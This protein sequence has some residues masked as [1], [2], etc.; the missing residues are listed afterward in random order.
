MS[1]ARAPNAAWMNGKVVPFAEARVPIE[2][3]GLQFGESLY[4]V[5]AVTAGEVRDLDAHVARMRHCAEEIGLGA[6]VPADEEWQRL[7][8]ALRERD[9]LDEGLLYAQ[10]TG[11][12]ARR[13]HLPAGEP[14]PSFWA[15]LREYRFP[16]AEDVERG[17]SAITLP[18]PR[19]SRCDLKTPMLLPAVMA[20]REAQ[21]RGA[22]EASFF[23][24]EED[25]REGGSSTAL[26][27]EGRTLVSPRQTQ[28]L[29]P[30]TTGP[31]IQRLAEQAGLEVRSEPVALDRLL[32]AA[33]V[34]V[35]STTFLL[36]P[37]VKVDDATIGQGR[38]GP[39]ALDLA[40]RLRTHLAL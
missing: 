30:G 17:L 4:E 40:A 7:I 3:R 28:H 1:S 15:Y 38:P 18:D 2:D 14:T 35:A 34:M 13:S 32:A 22:A 26:L 16:R 23:G 33:E 10:L 21:A 29:L 24:P 31:V 9:P 39:V 11:G 19:W 27:A 6:G 25:V 5:I 20:K 36:M 8:G 37:V 12:E